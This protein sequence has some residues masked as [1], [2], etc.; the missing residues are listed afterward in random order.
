MLPAE[1]LPGAAPRRRARSSLMVQ[2]WPLRSAR[3]G[4]HFPPRR[5]PGPCPGRGRLRRAAG[6]RCPRRAGVSARPGPAAPRGAGEGGSEGAG[7]GFGA[8]R[9]RLRRTLG[10]PRSPEG[11]RGEGDARF[12]EEPGHGQVCGVT[13]AGAASCPAKGC[14]C[15]PPT[16]GEPGGGRRSCRCG[17]WD[18]RDR[19][20][21]ERCPCTSGSRRALGCPGARPC[22]LSAPGALPRPGMGPWP[23]AGTRLPAWLTRGLERESAEIHRSAGVVRR[24]GG[25][26]E[27]HPRASAGLK[28]PCVFSLSHLCLP[29]CAVG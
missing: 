1:A 16:G 28:Q 11:L 25:R 12:V 15:A 10:C 2:L 21:A 27:L 3:P 7:W 26:A 4:R 22:G 29:S 18:R 23:A 13:G 9:Q 19:G 6:R 17:A 8:G 20:E 5:S 14:R 24:A